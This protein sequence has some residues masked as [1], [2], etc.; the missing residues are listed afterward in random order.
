VPF[1]KLWYHYSMRRLRENPNIAGHI[2]KNL[3]V[4]D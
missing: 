3:F 2:I 4:R 1:G